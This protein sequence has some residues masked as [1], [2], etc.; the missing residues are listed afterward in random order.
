MNTIA[1]AFP[2]TPQVPPMIKAVIN[3]STKFDDRIWSK[4]RRDLSIAVVGTI[5]GTQGVTVSGREVKSDKA[6]GV[7]IEIRFSQSDY[8]LL[9]DEIAEMESVSVN[10]LIELLQE[11]VLSVLTVKGVDT[12][13]LLCYG[14]LKAAEPGVA[15]IQGEK[16]NS[17]EE[18]DSFLAKAQDQ[19][20]QRMADYRAD[21]S[22]RL[23]A[24]KAEMEAESLSTSGV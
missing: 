13:S 22:A 12:N 4:E 11:P 23:K 9:V 10:V 6:Q 3:F 1:T 19:A 7:S 20:K 14:K 8:D 16:F 17:Q 5:L 15:N 21:Q 18:L 2:Q 24:A